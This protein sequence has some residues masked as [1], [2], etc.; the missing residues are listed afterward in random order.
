[1]RNSTKTGISKAIS[2]VQV[3]IIL[4]I[5]VLAGAVAYY[6]YPSSGTGTTS[7]T[8]TTAQ[9]KDTIVIGSTDSLECACTDPARAYDYFSGSWLSINLGAP[10]IDFA[11]GTTD[12]S[13]TAMKPALATSWSISSDGLTYTFILRSGLKFDDGHPFNSTAVK[14]SVDRGI[15]LND[16]DGPFAGIGIGSIIDHVDTPN[17]TAVV[18]HLKST[19]AP[20][21]GLL[22]FSA[23]YPVDPWR[24][25]ANS[26]LNFSSGHPESGNPFGLGP[27]NLTEW[28]RQGNVESEM[29]FD[30]NP[31]YWNYP[32]FPKTQHI[33]IRFFTDA[34]A[35]AAAVSAGDVDFGYR[36]FTSSDIGSFQSNAGLKVYSSPGAFIQYLVLNQH[37]APMNNTSVRQGIAA[38]LNRTDL[39]NTVFL[40]TA[41]PLY[42][43]VPLGMAYHSDVFKT[44]YGDTNIAQAQQLLGDAGYNSTNKLTVD[45]WY[46]SSGHYPQSGDQ[47]VVL[48][49]SL[50]ATGVISV[51]LQ[52]TD[53]G[54]Y[55]AQRRAG[56]MQMFIMGW[57][58]D[59]IDPFDYT[60]PFF[61]ASGSS[62]LNDGYNNTAMNDLIGQAIGSTSQS[63][64]SSLYQ[65]IQDLSAVDVPMVPL[66]QGGANC[67]GVVAKTSVGGIFLDVTLIFRM[68]TITETVT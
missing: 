13:P 31:N 1:M 50:E 42:S 43:Q 21:L 20:F 7:P 62:W 12:T 56:S 27:Y 29:K 61:Q 34:T 51:N 47:A 18:F 60:Q 16:P 63:Q 68:Y 36:Q 30:A 3:V 40:G 45:L 24:V 35:L 54:T 58:P 32:A 38:A 44:A 28:T 65:Q 66:Y 8:T 6:Y 26:V 23:M 57:Y 64:A 52:H 46:E 37:I 67:C 2:T 49:R 15:A 55:R 19:F 22:T 14:F 25:S 11:P 39:I 5:I 10:L 59:F 53:W 48:K 9:Y 4:V 41:T 17:S 33:I